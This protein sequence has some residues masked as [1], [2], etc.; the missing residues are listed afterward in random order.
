[1][2]CGWGWGLGRKKP[3]RNTGELTIPRRYPGHDHERAAKNCDK[4]SHHRGGLEI[5]PGFH[6]RSEMVDLPRL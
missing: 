3:V 5:V 2:S 6:A 1:V 4:L